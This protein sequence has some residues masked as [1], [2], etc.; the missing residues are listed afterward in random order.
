VLARYGGDEFTIVLPGRTVEEAKDL[1]EV[2]RV[3]L[4]EAVFLERDRGPDLPALRLTNAVTASLGVADTGLGAE[5]AEEEDPVQALLRRAD[6]AMYAAKEAGK[7][8]V[9]V[10]RP[11]GEP[12]PPLAGRGR[13]S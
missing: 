10:A 6:R 12:M 9:R 8:R 3:A 13:V 7:N 11:G 4:E 2:V 1:A 5:V